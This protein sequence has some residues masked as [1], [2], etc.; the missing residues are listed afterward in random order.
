M[1]KAGAF[2]LTG[3][4]LPGCTWFVFR[5]VLPPDHLFA[6]FL[7]YIKYKHKQFLDS[8]LNNLIR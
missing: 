1:S 3:R 6:F 2:F 5:S 7:N 4:H 8:L